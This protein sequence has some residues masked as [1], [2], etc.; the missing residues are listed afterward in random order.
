MGE[1]KESVLEIL[2]CEDEEVKAGRDEV[3]QSDLWGGNPGRGSLFKEVG[4][5]YLNLFGTMLVSLVVGFW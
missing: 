5:A 1:K 3:H 4:V 2:L